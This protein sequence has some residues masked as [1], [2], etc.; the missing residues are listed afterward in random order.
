MSRPETARPVAVIGA[1][2]DLGAGRRGVDMGPSAI[3]YAGLQ[4]RIASLGL[5]CVDW[6]DVDV[7]LPGGDRGRRLAGAVPRADHALV[8]AGG[9]PRRGGEP[10]RLRPAR[11]RRRPLG[12]DRHARRHGAGARRRAAR[13][14][15]TRTATSTRP[16]PRRAATCT[17]CRSRP[18]SASRE[19]RSRATPGRRRRSTASRSSASARSIA[20]ERELIGALEGEGVHDERH[21]PPRARARGARVAR[22]P[23]RLG[24]R[25]REPR[26]RRGR[27]DVRAGRRH[28]RPR[29]ALLPRGAPRRSSS[30]P[31]RGC[32]TRS[33]SSRSTR[34]STARTRPAPSRSSWRRALSAHG[35]SEP[36]TMGPASSKTRE[37]TPED[38]VP[39]DTTWTG[40]GGQQDCSWPAAADREAPRPSGT[41]TT[42][43][44][45][46]QVVKAG[47]K[48][49]R[50]CFLTVFL[51]YDATP[52]QTRSVQTLMVRAGAW[53]RCAFV[54]KELALKRFAQTN[55]TM[56]TPDAQEPLPELVTRSCRAAG[57]TSTGSSP[58]SPTGARRRERPRER[59]L[60]AT[61]DAAGGL[62]E[63]RGALGLLA[64][65]GRLVE[66][67][68]LQLVRQAVDLEARAA[69]SCG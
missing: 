46:A 58:S 57:S 42:A 66:D 63:P 24:V 65:A 28:A 26:P 2:L 4:E 48:P 29:R 33:S 43:P 61:P 68:A 21:R 30:W 49:P 50:G 1:G 12:R 22:V 5:E 41:T 67:R 59:A 17:A 13:C 52:R 47:S 19:T 27:P 18:R 37:R 60:R 38:G 31:S 51:A 35:S 25:A 9:R 7:S 20:A 15:S 45:A 64:G 55:P 36:G 34:S 3:R 53:R 39:R 54:S 11:A 69:S 40:R 56:A 14:G 8:R 32:S 6:G 44:P 62:P 10:R 16:R 23:A